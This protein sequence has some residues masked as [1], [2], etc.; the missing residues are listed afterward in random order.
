MSLQINYNTLNMNN[1]KFFMCLFIFLVLSDYSILLVCS[2]R[3]LNLTARYVHTRMQIPTI[4]EN[5]G[6]RRTRRI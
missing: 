3:A 2:T 6:D 4:T 5:S 1:N